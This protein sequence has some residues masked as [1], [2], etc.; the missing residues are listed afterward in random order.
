MTVVSRAARAML[1]EPGSYDRIPYFFSDQY[2]VGMEDS[3]YAPTWD[4]V[5]FRGDRADRASA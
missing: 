5:V 1:G 3:G 2:D 4:G